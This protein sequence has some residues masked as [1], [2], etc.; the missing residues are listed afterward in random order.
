MSKD[1]ELITLRFTRK[2]IQTFIDLINGS[3]VRSPSNP[4]YRV[5]LKL[6]ESHG[7]PELGFRLDEA[8]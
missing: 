3:D 7:D 1:D 2:E 5:T 4:R 8:K 6:D